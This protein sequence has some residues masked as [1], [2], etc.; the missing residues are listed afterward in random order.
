MAG[1]L[2]G[3]VAVVTGGAQGIGQAI[4]EKLAEQ[5]AD[6]VIADVQ[7]ERAA[8]LAQE[9]AGKLGRRTL[10]AKLDVTSMASAEAMVSQ[11]TE[12]MGRLDILVN[13]AGIARDTLLMRM[14]EADWDAVLGINLK[15]A[16]NCIKAAQ[17]AMMKQRY[18]RIVNISSV[19]GISGNVGQ[20][21]YAASKAGLIG[22]TKV[23]ARE[24][25]TRNITCN[26]VAPGFI[27]TA[28]TAKLSP[29]IVQQ[30]LK[31]IPSGKMGTPRDVANAVAFLVS[32]DASYV[33]GHVL[34]VDGG[35]VR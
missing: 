7:E 30:Y 17:R 31:N 25:A 28:M 15:G 23:V 2:E 11:V 18:G 14:S 10:A 35:M 1:V 29:E 4:A 3:R 24:F 16:F 26:A 20:A 6:V 13:N 5:G 19:V 32:D 12:A 21:N 22:L 33:N 34:V 8:A 27:E 9:I